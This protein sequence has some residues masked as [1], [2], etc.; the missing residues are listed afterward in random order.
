MTE[1]GGIQLAVRQDRVGLTAESLGKLHG[2]GDSHCRSE[3]A[4]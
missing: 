4:M 1:R 3:E 2:S